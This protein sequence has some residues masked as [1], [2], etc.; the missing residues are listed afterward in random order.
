VSLDSRGVVPADLY[1]ALP[2]A[3]AH[4]AQFA[5]AAIAAGAVAVLTDDAGAAALSADGRAGGIPV[6]TVQQPRAVLGD[7]AATVYGHPARALRMVGI[8]GTNGKTTTAYLVESGLRELGAHPGLIGTVETRIGDERLASVRT[9]PET[10]DLHAMLAVMRERSTDS[11]VMEVSSHALDQHRVDGVTFDVALFTNLSQDHL[12]YHGTLADYFEAKAALFTP[13]R[14][15]QG[16][17]CVDDEWGMAL[18]E[19]RGIPLVTLSS[20]RPA[21]WTVEPGAGPHLDL[22]GP[23]VRL[24]LPC[25]LPG[26]F[27]RV[28]TA[29]AAV[30]LIELGYAAADVQRAMA[31][32]PLVPGRMELVPGG[33]GD[34]RC[35]V[36]YAHTPDAVDAAL[37]ALRPSTAGL[38]VVVLGAGGDRDTTKRHAMGAAAARWADVVYV[39]DDNPRSEDPASIRAQVYA[40]AVDARRVFTSAAGRAEHIAEAVREARRSGHP[41]DNTVVVL[42]KGHET[43]QDIGGVVHPFDDRAALAAALRGE[44]YRPEAHG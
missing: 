6:L 27:N 9:T 26:T 30:A 21:E 15:R 33:V 8:T 11:V 23:G 12:E 40:G 22:A 42:G 31:I 24:R 4:G 3:H 19:R 2:G 37:A 1:A 43:G 32:E 25:H 10:T 18:A 28:N 16:V 17:V 38:L 41:T 5:G 39:T 20:R 29:M 7:L 14:A 44:P 36:D 13:A 34:P 35:I